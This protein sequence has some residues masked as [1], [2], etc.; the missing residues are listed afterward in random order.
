MRGLFPKFIVEDGSLVM[1]YVQYHSQIV[2]NKDKVNGGGWFRFDKHSKSCIFYGGSQDYGNAKL[3]HIKDCVR[4]RKVFMN[5]HKNRSLA[6]KY[7]F[8]YDTGM[9]MIELETNAVPSRVFSLSFFFRL[10]G[11]RF[12]KSVTFLKKAS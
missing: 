8:Y 12:Y 4:N 5:P 7:K 10:I 6:D 9:E 2:N 1:M 3:E 11:K